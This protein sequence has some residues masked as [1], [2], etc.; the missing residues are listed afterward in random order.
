M[1]IAAA[2]C[3]PPCGQS[4]IRMYVSKSWYVGTGL[5]KYEVTM[6]SICEND[7]EETARRERTIKSLT[8]GAGAS[9]EHVRRLFVAEQARLGQGAKVRNFLH[10]L[11]T[12]KVREMLRSA[13][14]RAGRGEI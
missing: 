11:T 5:L 10:I 14:N 4:P 6:S 1:T 12:S 7:K 13:R 9:M 8:D 3:A 2:I